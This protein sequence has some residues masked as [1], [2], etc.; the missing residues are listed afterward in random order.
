MSRHI[1]RNFATRIRGGLPPR[2]SSTTNLAVNSKLSVNEDKT[3]VE[4]KDKNVF[5]II[6]E[7]TENTSFQTLIDIINDG[8]PNNIVDL[9]KETNEQE[10]DLQLIKNESK[11]NVIDPFC[12]KEISTKDVQVKSD[13]SLDPIEIN[14]IIE[15]EGCNIGTNTNN[16][17]EDKIVSR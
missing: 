12:S 10:D 3:D 9:V 15:N 5:I 13:S 17:V 7:N 1:P 14:H 8:T 2:N 11:D 4:T 16:A 6:E